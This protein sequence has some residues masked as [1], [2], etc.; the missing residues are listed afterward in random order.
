ME[1][2]EEEKEE[3]EEIIDDNE[4]KKDVDTRGWID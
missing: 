2:K 3:K 1:D 4:V